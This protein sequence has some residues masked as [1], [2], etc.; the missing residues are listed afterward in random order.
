MQHQYV[1]QHI[2]YSASWFRHVFEQCISDSAVLSRCIQSHS[3]K[4]AAAI[5]QAYFRT[6]YP[7]LRCFFNSVHGSVD[8]K[9]Q[10]QHLR[11]IFGQCV[12]DWDV[13][14]TV[15]TDPLTG[16]SSS[17]NTSGIFRKVYPSLRCFFNSV[18]GP[19]D[20][21]QQQQQHLRLSD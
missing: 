3:R 19:F 7:W 11:H 2:L 4:A 6:L 5:P 17:S 18:H 14:L 8:R 13:F 1:P 12:P 16:S 10:Q 9:Q 20:R 15:H 21:K